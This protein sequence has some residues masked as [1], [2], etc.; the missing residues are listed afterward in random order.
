[1]IFYT[2]ITISYAIEFDDSVQYARKNPSL[3]QC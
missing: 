1:M 2:L 3:L